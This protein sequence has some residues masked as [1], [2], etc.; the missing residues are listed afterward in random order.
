MLFKGQVFAKDLPQI[1]QKL[2][3][4]ADS[5]QQ[6]IQTQFGV[7]PQK[8]IDTL[9]KGVSSLSKSGGNFLTTFFSGLLGSLTSFALILVYIFFLLW[10]REKYEEFFLK[11]TKNEN[12]PQ[13][14][15][16]LGQI[17]KVSSEYLA[18]RLLSML[19]LAILYGIGF[20]IIGLKNGVLLSIIAVIPT[21]IPYAGPFIGG[22]F[23]LAMAFIGG[24][25]GM[26]M[27]VAI[28]LIVAQ[29]L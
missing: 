4:V 13:A 3:Q 23:P 1:Q 20:S 24:S 15:E 5:L 2:T 8:Q 25:S 29:A 9:K 12:I 21:I 14:K 18:G 22:F 10:K 27:P 16:T 7:S 11:L 17:T 26:V 19:M 6:W 28:V